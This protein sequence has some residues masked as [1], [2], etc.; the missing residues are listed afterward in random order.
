PKRRHLRWALPLV[1]AALLG[2]GA[3]LWRLKSGASGSETPDM[4]AL[5][6]FA[7]QELQRG[8][9][10]GDPAVRGSAVEGLR[11]GR[12]PR[13]RGLLGARLRDPDPDVQAR[14]A[15]ALGELGSRAA[16]PALLSRLDEPADPTVRAALGEALQ[17][18]GDSA[19]KKA[20]TESL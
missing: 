12:D 13:Q 17:R 9:G 11:Q 15:R 16:T 5:R 14:A 8:L 10:D 4:L 18:L 19:G 3:L 6:S 1:A 2:G 20:L 7:L